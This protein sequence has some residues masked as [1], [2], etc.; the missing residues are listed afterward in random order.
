[1][2]IREGYPRPAAPSVPAAARIRAHG[3]G[4][5]LVSVLEHLEPAYGTKA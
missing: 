3:G 2:T 4:Q 1:M 5:Y